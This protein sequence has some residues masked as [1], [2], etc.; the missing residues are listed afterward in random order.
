MNARRI[1]GLL[2]EKV[3]ASNPRVEQIANA[4]KSNFVFVT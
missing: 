2:I 1:A 4:I 3:F